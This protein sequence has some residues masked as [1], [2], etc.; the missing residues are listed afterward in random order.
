MFLPVVLCGSVRASAWTPAAITNLTYFVPGPSTCFTDA[1]GTT[2]CGVGDGVYT[3]VSS[4]GPSVTLQQATS[5]ARLILRQDA[6]GKYY[7]EGANGRSMTSTG[8]YTTAA[9]QPF[10]LPWAGRIGADVNG[11]LLCFDKASP[12]GTDCRTCYLTPAWAFNSY[13]G[14]TASFTPSANTLASFVLDGTAVNPSTPRLYA[15]GVSQSFSSSAPFGG[16]A[17]HSL[18][19]NGSLSGL[20]PSG[21]NLVYGFGFGLSC[22]PLSAGELT[23][24]DTFQRGL[25][26]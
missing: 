13:F 12:A 7:L 18:S 16:S 10:V 24:L 6:G 9:N 5:G 15:D 2:P 3:M 22:G 11:M 19:L 17:G 26:A 1:G 14:N 20:Y 25:Y 8:T 4:Y 21:G 23:F